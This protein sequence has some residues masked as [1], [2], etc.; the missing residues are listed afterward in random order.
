MMNSLTDDELRQIKR[1]GQDPKKIFAAYQ[2]ALETPDKPTVILVKTVKGDAMGAS[3]QGRNTVHQKKNLNEDERLQ[4]ARNYGI[5]LD[6]EA[7]KRAEFYRPSEDSEEMQYLRSR[8]EQ[9]GGF[10]PERVVDCPT[11][12]TP[13]LS[14]FKSFLEGSGEREASTT[15]S[16][17]RMLGQLM[18]DKEIGDL[19]VPIVPDEARTF[20]MDGLFKAAG[21]YSSEGQK[22][23]PVD[24]DSLMSYREA[25]DGH[26]LQEGICETG[27]M[28]SFQAAGTAYAV[29]GVPTIPFYIFYSMFGFQRVG[30]MIWSCADMMC[31]GFLLGGTAG[32]TTLNG[33]GLQ[34]EDG[35]SHVLA[36]TVPNLKSYDPAFAYELAL[37]VREGIYRMYEQQENIFY[38][39]T[40]YNEN[41]VMPAMP[42]DDT[43]AEGVLKGVYCW[44][45]SESKGEPVQLMSSGSIMQQAIAAAE[46]LEA[47]GYA[48][49]I[50]S[51][52]SFTEL[53]R[54]AEACERH[55]RLN[56][57]AEQRVPYVQAL[58][59]NESG[60]II[61][62]TDYMKAL[63][64][65]ISR[66][67]P[68]G[69]TTLGTDGFGLSESRP[70]L[71]DHFEISQRHIV[72]AAL[73][74]M[75]RQ[76]KLKKAALKKQLATL[77]IAAEKLDPMAR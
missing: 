37:I 26:I 30:D 61:A 9:L 15:M 12:K 8:R 34:H 6:A 45:R 70:D 32:R 3:A 7:I 47:Q 64:N 11:L 5:P 16:M 60:P 13:A 77:G 44:R 66:W 49:H 20:G 18:K 42:E 29:H 38:Y 52:T 4:L 24:A 41:H 59:E 73:V 71:R 72:Q 23:T 46:M 76:G 27:A 22:Y 54:E 74:S 40:V 51:V 67:M 33:E 65:G 17:V 10:L 62:V 50:W 39:I 53:A 21:I 19:V 55:N 58:F 48:A 1:G 31:R 28:A 36:T 68:T 43:I 56:P 63:P 35:H 75:Y 14:S 25:T 2:R 57:L 69:Y